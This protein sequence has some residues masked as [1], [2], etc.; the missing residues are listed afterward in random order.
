MSRIGKNPVNLPKEVNAEFVNNIIN[1][2]G[3]K[4]KLSFEVKNNIKLNIKNDE[5]IISRLDDSRQQKSMHGTVRQIINNMVI[6]VSKGFQKELTIIG[7]GYQAIMQG[8]RLQLQLGFSHDII[9][10]LPEGIN[11]K[12]NRTELLIEGVDKQLVGLVAAKIRSFRKPEPYKGK[13]IRYKNEYVQS[14]QGKTV[15]TK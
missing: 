2:T 4:G 12:A 11:I 13:G 14:K 1:I 8:K 6:G 9:F 15:G 10:E 3:P 5:I 7:V